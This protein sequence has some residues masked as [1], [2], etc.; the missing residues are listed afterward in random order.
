MKIVVGK[1]SIEI[2]AD[3]Q[4]FCPKRFAEVAEMTVAIWKELFAR[5]NNGE[6]TSLR[7]EKETPQNETR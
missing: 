2:N 4:G 3:E 5:P 6:E 7:T 1:S